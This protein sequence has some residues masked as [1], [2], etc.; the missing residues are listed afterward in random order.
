MPVLTLDT[1]RLPEATYQII[2]AVEGRYRIKVERIMPDARRSRVNGRA[3]MARSVPRKPLPS[4]CSAA[5]FRKVR[6]LA[7]GM[8]AWRLSS[9]DAPGAE[10]IARRYRSLRSLR[11]T[12]KDQPAGGLDHRRRRP[13]IRSS[14]GCPNIPLRRGIL[15][16]SAAIPA[17]ARYAPVRTNVR[18]AGGGK[19]DAAKEC[20]L[21]FSADGRPSARL[22]CCCGRCSACIGSLE[23]SA[24]SRSG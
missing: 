21:H 17:R 6:P 16:A 1:G 2:A 22:T 24:A 3:R 19:L 23:P 8:Q 11:R 20:G 15:P 9:R 7:R 4:A 13:N 10:R 14:T 18:D 5:R 12:C